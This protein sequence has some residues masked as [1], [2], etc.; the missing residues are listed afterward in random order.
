METRYTNIK[1]HVLVMNLHEDMWEK[2]GR[3]SRKKQMGKIR[4][5]T[6][7]ISAA[8]LIGMSASS[9][10]AEPEAAEEFAVYEESVESEDNGDSAEAAE[11][12]EAEDT[13]DSFSAE[14]AAEEE[15][16]YS[17]EEESE[18]DVTEEIAQEYEPQESEEDTEE[19]VFDDGADW[20]GTAQS[21][22]DIVRGGSCGTNLEWAYYSDDTLVISGTGDMTDYS[23]SY[24]CPWERYARSMKKAII[25]N[26]VTSIGKRAFYNC[27][28]LTTVEIGNGVTSIGDQAFYSC[29]GLTTAKLG[30][31]VTSLGAESFWRCSS[32]TTINIPEKVTSIGNSAFDYCGSLSSI[33]LPDGIKSIGKYAFSGCSKLTTV[34][35]G[36]GLAIIGDS[37]FSSCYGLAQINI[38]S[39][40]T[41]IGKN[42]FSGC[43]SIQRVDIENTQSF[44]ELVYNEKN[45]RINQDA[46]AVGLYCNGN[47]VTDIV[48]PDGT[49]TVEKWFANITTIESI[50][51]PNSVTKVD[52]D[53]FKGCTN[54]KK[55]TV[56]SGLEV[57]GGFSRYGTNVRSFMD[58]WGCSGQI[59]EIVFSEGRTE[60]GQYA[61]G[62]ENLKSVTLPSTLKKVDKTAFRD[63][64]NLENLYVP[65]LEEWLKLS[66]GIFGSEKGTN[67]YAGGKL[68]TD[69]VVPDSITTIPEGAFY[70]LSSL[71]SVTIPNSVTDIGKNAFKYCKNLEKLTIGNGMFLEIPSEYGLYTGVLGYWG[72]A[73]YVKTVVIG[74]GTVSIGDYAFYESKALE[75]VVLANSVRNLGKYVFDSCNNLKSISLSQWV[76]GIGE[77]AVP[78]YTT[79][80]CRTGSRAHKYAIQNKLKVVKS[81]TCM[82][83][84]WKVDTKYYKVDQTYHAR[85]YKCIFCGQKKVVKSKHRFSSKKVTKMAT[86]NAKGKMKI[87]C[88]DC[89][90]YY[91][92]QSI[93][94]KRGGFGCQN[95]DI[96]KHST[97]YRTSKNITVYL[98]NPAKGAVVQV[99]VGKRTFKKKI[100]SS[101][102]KVTIPV[103]NLSYGV[104]ARISVYYKNK[105]IGS[106]KCYYG[107]DVVYYARAVTTGM[108][109]NQ[110]RYTLGKSY[111]IS[112]SSYGYTTWYYSGGSV[113]FKNGRVVRWF[114]MS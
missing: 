72:C 98:K 114:F 110:V 18:T 35:I 66:E 31:G 78:S 10:Y 112:N 63:V 49:T 97:I 76:T 3:M 13:Q 90:T 113:T 70:G 59:E 71:K 88:N 39:S 85:G 109:P 1:T 105:L 29:K 50:V 74:D 43:K 30:A 12:V 84:E 68:V 106:D 19:A 47:P 22:G 61:L 75:K 94:W 82:G 69:L 93:S 40:V 108:T 64:V 2:R 9:V 23:V 45:G 99:K 7:L 4:Q 100:T 44:L 37:A 51:I 21:S 102:K 41:S 57:K 5:F 83:H 32:L 87:Y 95:Y 11:S 91:K 26:R 52:F 46:G 33:E 38:P 73:D 55:L 60:I 42:A 86:F 67:L 77:Y 81:G 58:R 14:A 6:A 89:G 92:E 27:V 25:E 101:A 54:L 56:G 96:T 15:D 53:A 103:K 20:A 107:D 24:V 17:E 65:N 16:I 111:H 104:K 62:E 80:Y 34:K 36:S 79:V 8:A 28:A 48:I